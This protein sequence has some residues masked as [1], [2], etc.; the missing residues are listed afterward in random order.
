MHSPEKIEELLF[1][2]EQLERS[3]TQDRQVLDQLRQEVIAFR[4]NPELHTETTAF[5]SG[6]PSPSPIPPVEQS[7]VGPD[8]STHSPQTNTLVHPTRRNLEEYIGGNLV[9]KIGI[10][11]LVVGVGIFMKYAIDSELIGPLGRVTLGY[12]AGAILLLLAYGLRKKYA[13]YSAVLLSGGVATLYFSTFVA[14]D[15][16]ALLPHTL[17][18]ALM[19]AVTIFTVYAAT[20]FN[21]EVI[22]VMGLVGAYAVPMLLSQDSGR[23]AALFTY[24]AIIN[25]GVVVLAYQKEWR[26]MNGAAFVITWL[27]FGIWFFFT[28]EVATHF[29]IALSFGFVFFL[30]FFTV[31]SFYQHAREQLHA[32]N[33]VFLLSNAFLFYGFTIATLSG[34]SHSQLESVFTFVYALL[35]AGVAYCIYYKKWSK[36]LFYLITSLSLLFFT[37]TIPIQWSGVSVTFIWAAEALILYGISQRVAEP[38]YI[39]SAFVIAGLSVLSLLDDWKVYYSE[40]TFS[41]LLNPFFAANI[42]VVTALGGMWLLFREEA[43]DQAPKRSWISSIPRHIFPITAVVL[44]YGA[45][46]LEIHHFF[47]SNSVR[48]SP[49]S[50]VTGA[51]APAGSFKN[52]WVISFSGVYIAGLSLLLRFKT[53]PGVWKKALIGLS[54]AVFGVW[55]L[56]GL[57]AAEALRNAYIKE[58]ATASLLYIWIRYIT[59]SCLALCIGCISR[60]IIRSDNLTK[61]PLSIYY[62]VVIH[63]FILAVLSVELLHLFILRT[64]VSDITNQKLAQKV[65]FSVLWGV[66]ALGLISGGI[67]Q[68][69]K[70]LR[71]LGIGLFGITLVKLF[72]FDLAAISTLGKIIAFIGLGILLLVISFLYQRFKDIILAEDA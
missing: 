64:G 55:L 25:T 61:T 63:T 12:A 5:S 54:I 70:L 41:F 44:L 30:I 47:D 45:V 21:Q 43:T 20:A 3:M 22:G 67:W 40:Q 62:P 18:F 32:P 33:A 31:L 19:V 27:I 14:Y 72:V 4:Q 42:W 26:L 10:L 1:R 6:I 28:Y 59:Y 13:A 58:D 9:N 17:A 52:L 8:L 48:T 60:T 68:K 24:M 7:A 51:S 37:L 15:F 49:A 36:H 65:G 2:I 11:I 46:V 66:Y 39:R 34:S 71:M 69:R 53:L 38:F 35:H 56:S 16:Y 23:I 57:A 29:Y 50:L